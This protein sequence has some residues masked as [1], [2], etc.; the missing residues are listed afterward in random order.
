MKIGSLEF[1]KPLVLAPMEEISDV[2]FRILCR[3]RG[4]DYVVTE[5]TSSEALIRDIPKSFRKAGIIDAE[6]PVAIQLFGSKPD[7]MVRAAQIV[8]QSCPDVIDINAG[9]WNKNHALRGE[10]AGLL[11]DLPLMEKMI[12]RIVRAVDIPVTVKTRLGWDQ[13]SICIT[14]VARLVEQTGAAALTVHARTRC[15]GYKGRADWAWFE[16]IKA[17]ISIPLIGNGD[18][19]TPRDVER[20]F[21]AGCDGVMIGRAALANPWIF[22]Q[23]RQYFKTNRV[24]GPPALHQRVEDC[25]EHLRLALR[26]RGLREGVLRFR[27]YYAGYLHGIPHSSRLRSELMDLTDPDQIIER[28]RRFDSRATLSTPSP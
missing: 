7:V 19:T 28:L 3:R 2:P 6:R 26:Y 11:R 8:A 18:A 14:D 25:I 16:K 5:F 21:D 20:I 23:T 1:E 15:Q 17:A 4:A 12:R 9:C 10:G 22:E 24:P 13:R 27:K